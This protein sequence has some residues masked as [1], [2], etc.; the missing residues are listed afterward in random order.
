MNAQPR[1]TEASLKEVRPGDTV[2]IRYVQRKEHSTL[3]TDALG[4]VLRLH[5]DVPCVE[6][7]VRSKRIYFDGAWSQGRDVPRGDP[8]DVFIPGSKHIF[9]MRVL[10]DSE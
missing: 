4:T 7:E 6:I 8:I 1:V 9:L 3:I 5:P 2:I 10:P